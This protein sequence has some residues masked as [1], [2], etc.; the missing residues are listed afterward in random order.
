MPLRTR[1]FRAAEEGRFAQSYLLLP[2]SFLWGVFVCLRNWLYDRRLLSIQRLGVPVISVGNLIAGGVGKTPLVDFLAQNISVRLALLSRG[3]RA[4]RGEIGDEMKMLLR[5][6]PKRVQGYSGKDRVRLGQE[7]IDKGAKL[8]ILDLLVLDASNPFGY[9]D[10]LP[11]GL[12]RDP[13]ERI[14]QADAIFVYGNQPLPF[15]GPIIRVA[16]TN[17]K[18]IEYVSGRQI[19]KLPPKIGA[20]CAIGHPKRFLK[21]LEN[22]LIVDQFFLADHEPFSIRK[23]REFALRCQK[24][25]AEAIVCTEKDA[26]KLEIPLGFPLPVVYLEMQMEILSGQNYWEALLQRIET[27]HKPSFC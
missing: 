21:T 24:L 10:Y 1:L 14:R 2:F 25:G 7:A 19:K 26:I 4:Q 27:V 15:E 5:R 17:S 6:L 18:I 12:L 13:P 8:L 9:G 20:F 3:Y 16:L 23:L 11:R 22:Q